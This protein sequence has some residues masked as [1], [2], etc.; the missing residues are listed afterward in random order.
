MSEQ[1]TKKIAVLPGDGIG[2]EVT[3]QAV[4]VLHAI[5]ERFGYKF[6]FS[7]ALIGACAIDQTGSPLPQ[8]T[9]DL[10]ESADAILLG[11]VG[12]PKYDND[13]DAKVRPE[14]GL[15]GLRKSLGLYL[16]IRPMKVY[17]QMVQ[18]SNLKAEV[19]SGVDLTIYRELG[20]GIYFGEKEE[21]AEGSSHASDLCLYTVEEV[22][23]VVRDA[24]KAAR[25]R[26]GKLCVV[27]KANVLAS[28]RLWRKTARRLADENPDVEVSY[29][30][31][32]NAAMQLVLNPGQFDVIVTSNM[33]GDI[34][35]DLASTIGGSI[36]LLP[37]AS[38]GTGPALFEPVHGSYPEATGK[39]IA[40]PLAMILS[41][42][43]ML[44]HFGLAE[45]AQTVRYGVEDCLNKGLG[46][47]DLHPEHEVGCAH[48]GDMVSVAVH[49]GKIQL[50]QSGTSTGVSTII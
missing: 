31:V 16:N 38:I 45:A 8:E 29:M 4:K 11:A 34:L 10:C 18:H 32:D 40:N 42:A 15:L 1:I 37:S 12:A 39:D 5:E 6:E 9:I 28:S 50:K 2:P 13:P 26:R 23:R 48:L 44:D 14:Q 22:E 41:V 19:I 3:H 49:D 43:Q 27:D 47:P 30:Y 33:F 24:F 35:S 36:G 25:K 7:K 17:E 21:L 20:S 46:T